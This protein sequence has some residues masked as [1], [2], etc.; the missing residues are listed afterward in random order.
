MAKGATRAL[1]SWVGSLRVPSER[2]WQDAGSSCPYPTRKVT[3]S[4]VLSKDEANLTSR[5]EIANLAVPEMPGQ[6]FQR[7]QGRV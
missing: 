1:P 6:G 7:M 5:E 3:N 4:Q 2:G